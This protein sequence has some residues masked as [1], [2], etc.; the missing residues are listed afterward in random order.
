MLLVETEPVSLAMFSST[1]QEELTF[2]TETD[3]GLFILERDLLASE[4]VTLS[5]VLVDDEARSKEVPESFTPVRRNLLCFWVCSLAL[6]IG[7]SHSLQSIALSSLQ[8]RYARLSC[9]PKICLL[10]FKVQTVFLTFYSI[11]GKT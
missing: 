3:L 10:L 2:S 1:L 11:N 7:R 5:V 9:K 8:N 6:C 4:L